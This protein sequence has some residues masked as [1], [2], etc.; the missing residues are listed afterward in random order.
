MNYKCHFKKMLYYSFIEFSM[1]YSLY[2]V[3]HNLFGRRLG[4]KK[5]NIGFIYVH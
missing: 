4:K 3:S 2:F 1:I 5:H